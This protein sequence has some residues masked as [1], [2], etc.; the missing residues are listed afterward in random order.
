M[1]TLDFT[2]TAPFLQLEYERGPITVR[3]G[4]R[5]ESADLRVDTYTTL[6]AYGS[7][8][9]QGGERSFSKTVKNV[10]AVWRFAPQWSAFVS[11]AEGFGLPLIEVANAL[12][13]FEV[14]LP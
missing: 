4:V 11:S 1:P 14:T 6:A 12:R 5:R 2:L 13:Q 10:G 9:V 7:R 8:L 3:G